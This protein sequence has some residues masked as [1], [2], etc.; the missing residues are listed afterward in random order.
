M[1][2]I[3]CLLHYQADVNVVDHRTGNTV[4]LNSC[5]QNNWVV[6]ENITQHTTQPINL[7]IIN[8]NGESARQLLI[9]SN[10]PRVDW[11]VYPL[12]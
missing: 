9:A 7:D 1:N 10:C 8:Y 3:A 4:F 12:F 5:L 2:I 6:M 11:G